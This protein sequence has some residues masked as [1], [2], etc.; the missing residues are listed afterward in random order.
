VSCRREIGQCQEQNCA[1]GGWPESGPILGKT[2]TL[3]GMTETSGE[4][5]DRTFFKLNT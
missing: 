5:Q 2:G 3:Y 4:Y 1:D